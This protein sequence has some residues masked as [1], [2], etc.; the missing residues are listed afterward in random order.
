MI[1][2]LF[3]CV[4]NK[5]LRISASS[6][7]QKGHLISSSS[8]LPWHKSFACGRLGC[9]F[10]LCLVMN[11][12]NVICNMILY[13]CLSALFNWY[14]RTN[15]NIN[16]C[17]QSCT[18][19]AMAVHINLL[20]IQTREKKAEQRTNTR[21]SNSPQPSISIIDS[22]TVQ[23]LFMS[24]RRESCAAREMLRV[25]RGAQKDHNSSSNQ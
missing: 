2:K 23:A 1:Q 10:C 24:W 5:A 22:G 20:T 21:R 4:C 8:S 11:A 12:K 9:A 3:F 7:T 13:S 15:A 18:N 25:K 6:S 19:G 14:D 17:W 16:C